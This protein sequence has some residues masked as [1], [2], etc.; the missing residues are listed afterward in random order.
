MRR[1]R[2]WKSKA[3]E[4][5]LWAALSLLTAVVM[6]SLSEQLLPSNF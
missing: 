2:S 3:L 5:A 6:V 4:F 1:G